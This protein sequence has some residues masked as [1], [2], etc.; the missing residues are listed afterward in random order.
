MAHISKS[1]YMVVYRCDYCAGNTVFYKQEASA[2]HTFKMHV[3]IVVYN[4]DYCALDTVN[5]L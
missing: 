4:P 5:C 1:M 2:A 3:Y